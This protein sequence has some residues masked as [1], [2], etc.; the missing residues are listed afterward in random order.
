MNIGALVLR[1]NGLDQSLTVI[2]SDGNLYLA[3]VR[4][5]Q[6]IL[7]E[8]PPAHPSTVTAVEAHRPSEGNSDYFEQTVT[9]ERDQRAGST[10]AAAEYKRTSA[11][12]TA[13]S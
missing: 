10:D 3:L 4:R 11:A 9:L 6:N 1:S 8:S 12:A 5:S 7:P 2:S 13:G